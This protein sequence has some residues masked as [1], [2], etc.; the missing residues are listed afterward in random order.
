MFPTADHVAAAIVAAAREV[1]PDNW[2]HVAV[3]VASGE[4]LSHNW[5]NG[6]LEVVRSRAYAAYALRE[7]FQIGSSSVS[8]MVGASSVDAYLS[9]IDSRLRRGGMPWWNLKVL[10]IVKEAIRKQGAEQVVP[11]APAVPARPLPR[12]AESPRQLAARRMLE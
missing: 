2:K 11:R 8:R 4:R 5:P 3:A 12:P 1:A 7:F 6:N 10:S 9:T